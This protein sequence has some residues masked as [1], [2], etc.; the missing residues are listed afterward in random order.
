MT[1]VLQNLPSKLRL[2]FSF[3]RKAVRARGRIVPAAGSRDAAVVAAAVGGMA[4]IA[5]VVACRLQ[6][7]V[8]EIKQVECMREVHIEVYLPRTIML[9]VHSLHVTPY[10]VRVPKHFEAA[11]PVPVETLPLSFYFDREAHTLRVVLKE[12]AKYFPKPQPELRSS[13]ALRAYLLKHPVLKEK[14]LGF[15][16]TLVRPKDRNEPIH[17]QDLDL[18]PRTPSLDLVE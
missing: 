8:P 14:T 18:F 15:T 4:V 5:L 6:P 9:S 2:K 1:G 11:L 16:N 17:V 3:A 10:C 13:L 7:N 12:Q